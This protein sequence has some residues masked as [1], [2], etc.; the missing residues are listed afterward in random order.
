MSGE[1][2]PP[3]AVEATLDDLPSVDTTNR[4]LKPVATITLDEEPLPEPSATQLLDPITSRPSIDEVPTDPKQRAR[5]TTAHAPV[6]DVQADAVATQPR[7]RVSLKSDA[8]ESA[9]AL[10]PASRKD[11]GHRGPPSAWQKTSVWTPGLIVLTVVGVAMLL[12]ALVVLL[13]S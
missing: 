10:T 1:K 11:D 5:P 9:A 3:G 12:L 4:I 7:R 2:K 8:F 6:L 13:R